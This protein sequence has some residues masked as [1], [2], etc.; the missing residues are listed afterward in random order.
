M[1]LERLIGIAVGIARSR[2]EEPMFVELWW[3]TLEAMKKGLTGDDFYRFVGSRV[4][5]AHGKTWSRRKLFEGIT[6]S[7]AVVPSGEG[8]VDLMDELSVKLCDF[9]KK[10]VTLLL[11]GE[12]FESVCMRLGLEGWLL[13]KS[14]DRIVDTVKG[15]V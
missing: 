8:M 9:D 4:R 13:T 5:W 1:D 14:I 2:S 12:S 3:F 6:E 15:K 10:V 7:S 11:E